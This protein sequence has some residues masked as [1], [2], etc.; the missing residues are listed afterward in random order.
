MFCNMFTVFRGLSPASRILTRSTRVRPPRSEHTINSTFR[1]T[2]RVPMGQL[3]TSK[4]IFIAAMASLPLNDSIQSDLKQSFQRF[5]T[6]YGWNVR[7]QEESIND[8][9][10]NPTQGGHV[11]L[12]SMHNNNGLTAHKFPDS[13][14]CAV[15]TENAFSSV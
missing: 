4:R 3:S 13:V 2:V 9:G 15:S 5:S 1:Y 6:S 10:V 12:T 8:I 11:I 14:S 7:F